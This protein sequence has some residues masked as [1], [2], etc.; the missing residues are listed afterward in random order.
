MK[1]SMALNPFRAAWSILSVMLWNLHDPRETV[2]I[3][4]LHSILKIEMINFESKE[5]LNGKGR[6]SNPTIARDRYYIHGVTRSFAKRT[7]I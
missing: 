5:L 3:A 7:R 4:G 6:D 2:V 1:S